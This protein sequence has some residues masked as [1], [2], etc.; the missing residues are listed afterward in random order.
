MP[1]VMAPVLA[2]F[3]LAFVAAADRPASSARA[4]AAREE[5]FALIEKTKEAIVGRQNAFKDQRDKMDR[6]LKGNGTLPDW[7]QKAMMPLDSGAGSFIQERAE[8]QEQSGPK[9]SAKEMQKAL[10]RSYSQMLKKAT[11]KVK[12][13][14]KRKKHQAHHN[15]HTATHEGASSFLEVGDVHSHA[16]DFKYE[17]VA[18]MLALAKEQNLPEPTFLQAQLQPSSSLLQAAEATENEA[19]A[20]CAD[21]CQNM[22]T[23]QKECYGC[24]FWP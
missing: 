2:F 17:V 24:L 23:G 13:D 15:K 14:R 19:Q 10:A 12:A 16:K 21:W 11:R 6:W 8:A 4:L 1:S 9:K 5:R 22:K 20:L 7:Q 3:A 18:K